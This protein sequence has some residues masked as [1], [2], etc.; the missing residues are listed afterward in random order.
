MVVTKEAAMAAFDEMLSEAGE[1]TRPASGV[2]REIDIEASP[3]EVFEALVTEEGRERWLDEP[4][5]DIHVESIDPPSRL[6]WW[7]AS[8]E[9]P[10]TRVDFEIVALPAVE[11][12]EGRTRV[13]VIETAP[14]FPIA[15][16]AAS[17]ALV[18]A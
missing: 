2:R 9:E 6:T 8:E 14:R 13:T 1:D 10:F 18:A 17:F 5:R 15:A 12:G 16:M 7:W 11:P 3:E 4:D